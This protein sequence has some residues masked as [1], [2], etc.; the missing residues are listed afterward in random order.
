[1][2]REDGVPPQIRATSASCSF[3]YDRRRRKAAVCRRFANNL[4]QTRVKERRF[5]GVQALHFVVIAVDS[6]H[7]GWVSINPLSQKAGWVTNAGLLQGFSRINGSPMTT[8]IQLNP[9]MPR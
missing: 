7:Q 5:A 4:F 2:S 1:V 3:H 6:D 8:F 9:G